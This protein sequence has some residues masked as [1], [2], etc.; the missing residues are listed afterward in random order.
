MAKVQEVKEIPTVKVLDYPN[1]PEKKSF[2]PRLLIVFL[3]MTLSFV[4]ATTWVFGR[5]T[6]D[7][8]DSNDPR[9]RFAQE[10]FTTV[11]AAIP[12]FSPN[13][14]AEIAGTEKSRHWFRGRGQDAAQK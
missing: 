4:A 11:R 6:W 2:P 13:G 7:H 9:K 12:H 3:G 8:A 1:I 10:V 14:K 5:T